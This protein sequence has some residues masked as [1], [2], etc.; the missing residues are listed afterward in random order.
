MWKEEQGKYNR[1]KGHIESMN[2]LNSPNSW[3]NY[4]NAQNGRGAFEDEGDIYWLAKQFGISKDQYNARLAEIAAK[5]KPDYMTP[6]EWQAYL[7]GN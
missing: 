2:M 7:T 4:L 5:A 1:L 3:I 6:G